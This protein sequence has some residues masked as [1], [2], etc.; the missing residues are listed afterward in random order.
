MPTHAFP[1]TVIGAGANVFGDRTPPKFVPPFAWGD[2]VPF[3]TWEIEKLLAVAERVMQR[4]E[5]ALGAGMRRTLEAAWA[6]RG[7]FTP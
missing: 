1:R 6:R 4:R 3:E 7:A 5:V 2:G